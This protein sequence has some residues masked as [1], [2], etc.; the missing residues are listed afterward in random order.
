VLED[1]TDEKV[2]IFLYQR[3]CIQM[4]MIEYFPDEG[5]PTHIFSVMSYLT[6]LFSFA[7]M[8]EKSEALEKIHSIYGF[9]YQERLTRLLRGFPTKKR[10]N[11]ILSE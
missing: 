10:S 4:G 5:F 1:L 9:S 8:N 11:P 7:E 6:N 3:E 2:H